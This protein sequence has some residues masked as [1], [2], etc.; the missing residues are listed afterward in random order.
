M[1]V[2]IPEEVPKPPVPQTETVLTEDD[3]FA[4]EPKKKVKLVQ[5]VMTY[6]V[7]KF[8]NPYDLPVVRPLTGEEFSELRRLLGV[9][10]NSISFMYEGKELEIRDCL[11]TEIPTDYL[12]AK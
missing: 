3:L 9:G 5:P 11:V 6:T 12:I 8:D 2:F 7:P 4:P 10:P 1:P